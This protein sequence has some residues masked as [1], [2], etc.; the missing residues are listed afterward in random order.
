[1][2]ALLY[3]D[4]IMTCN[5]SPI[6]DLLHVVMEQNTKTKNQIPLQYAS[7]VNAAGCMYFCSGDRQTRYFHAISEK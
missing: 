4:G 1:M 6:L 7:E 5:C 3:C 2:V